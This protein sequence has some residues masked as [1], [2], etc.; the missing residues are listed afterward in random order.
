[1][2]GLRHNFGSSSSVPVENLRN[3]KWLDEHGHTPSIMD[4]ARF[5]YIAQPEDKID[6]T[7]LFPRIGEYD[8]W[9]IEWG[10]RWYPQF[11]SSKDEDTYLNRIV[12]DK[13][14]KNPRLVFGTEADPTEPRNHNE[15]LG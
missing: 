15:D 4:Y 3:K 7:G 1:T 13:L 5:N 11:N 6:E 2:L 8:K 12:I 14:S 10:Y 9:A